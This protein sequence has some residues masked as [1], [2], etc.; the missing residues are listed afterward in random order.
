MRKSKAPGPAHVRGEYDRKGD[1]G[2]MR[3][4][5]RTDRAAPDAPRNLSRREFVRTLAAATAGSGFIGAAVL[6][7][8]AAAL[9]HNLGAWE[10]AAERARL[11]CAAAPVTR[12]PQN[13]QTASGGN[14]T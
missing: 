3:A 1:H 14:S 12:P 11:V 13:T 6:V 2:T 5:E 4:E 7:F 10:Y 8:Q 9:E